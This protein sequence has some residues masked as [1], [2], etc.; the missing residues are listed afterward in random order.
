MSNHVFA[1]I[2]GS[3]TTYFEPRLHTRMRCRPA[4]AVNNHPA[5]GLDDSQPGT[6]PFVKA[7]GRAGWARRQNAWRITV[8][9]PYEETTAPSLSKS[10]SNAKQ[11]RTKK[12]RQF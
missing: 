6:G 11:L 7:D 12:S 10:V 5:A 9:H 3:G 8:A 4:G 2:S 1:T